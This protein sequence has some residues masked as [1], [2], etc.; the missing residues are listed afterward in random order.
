MVDSG[1]KVGRV[2][3]CRISEIYKFVFASNWP[4]VKF[5]K[6]AFQ[7]GWLF[8][9]RATY[10]GRYFFS[11][12]YFLQPY[13]S[14]LGNLLLTFTSVSKLFFLLHCCMSV[15]CCARVWRLGG[16]LPF[17]SFPGAPV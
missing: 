13:F 4:L 7:P 9:R 17:V 11:E 10:L 1:S 15:L 16:C 14:E 12:S 2:T 3:S 6:S 5:G 8:F